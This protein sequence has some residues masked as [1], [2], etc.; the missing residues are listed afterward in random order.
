METPASF[1]YRLD[2]FKYRLDTFKGPFYEFP[3]WHVFH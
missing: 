3:A 1:K 2:T